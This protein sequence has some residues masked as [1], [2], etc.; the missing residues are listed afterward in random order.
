MDI[1]SLN[2]TNVV[3]NTTLPKSIDEDK[4][5]VICYGHLRS[6][7]K[8]LP[9]TLKTISKYGNLDIYIHTWDCID[10]D[11]SDYFELIELPTII[12]GLIENYN[13]ISIKVDRQTLNN[14]NLDNKLFGLYHMYY[15]MWSANKLKKIVEN[16]LLQ[17]YKKCFKLRPDVF[18]KPQS[19]EDI[20]K[21]NIFFSHDQGK[22][23]DALAFT[24][25]FNMDL[26]CSYISKINLN[27]NFDLIQ[28]EYYHFLK[29]TLKLKEANYK[30]PT[31]WNILRVRYEPLNEE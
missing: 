13:L 21:E 22:Y 30:Y 16:N 8:C 7:L 15:S 25:S 26:I 29:H 6:F 11:S 12:S 19:K 5:A 1:R 4:I 2:I 28:S 17:R 9:V 24:S 23:F 18:F 14:Q 31:D 3:N 20:L 10:L 27:K